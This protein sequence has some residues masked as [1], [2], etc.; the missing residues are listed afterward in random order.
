[1]SEPPTTS[2]RSRHLARARQ[3]VLM[4]VGVC[5]AL[6]ILGIFLEPG[7][8]QF[9][10][11]RPATLFRAWLFGWLFWFGISLGSMGV[12]MMHYLLGG[13]WGY[14][15]RRFGEAA[16]LCAPVMAI[17]FI[18][19]VLGVRYIYPWA[20]PDH[21]AHDPILQ[22]KVA[23]WLN[24]PFWISKAVIYFVVF[25]LM[26]LFLRSW[27]LSLDRDFRPAR[28]KQLESFS[29]VGSVIYFA[30]M[31]LAAID[32]VM[33]LDPHWV[34]TVFG[35][36]VVIGQVLS[37]SCFL[38]L[39]LAL[40]AD[41]SP[42]NEVIRP[43]YLNDLGSILI[44]FVILWSYLSFAQFL[45]SWLGNEQ[46]E[47]TWYIRRTQG[48]WRWV[49][50]TLILVH[51]LVPFILLLMRPIKQK[52][53]R[54][55][56]VAGGVLLMRALDVFYWIGPNT[57]HAGTAGAG[58]WLYTCLMSFIAWLAVGGLWFLA[59]SWFLS[60]APILPIGDRIPVIPIDHG[61]GQRP[62]S[63]AGA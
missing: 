32:W 44:T 35:F 16:A 59:F 34:S 36:I 9:F 41:E 38:I 58:H 31:T 61:H 7:R 10:H 40:H 1:M 6:L 5:V 26:A 21:V 54:L 62:A 55:A 20:M 19:V 33:S 37:A 14:L 51:F 13:G 8:G 27:S 23:H 53:G 60:G 2:R 22:H 46:S 25:S 49:G 12:L 52:L 24:L 42:L 47:I 45:V 29:A 50:G 3:L 4:G 48:G 30:L 57:T 43:N 63:A 28:L 56:A 11:V 17:L 39:M 15:I 18:P